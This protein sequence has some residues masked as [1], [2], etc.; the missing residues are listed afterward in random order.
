MAMDLTGILQGELDKSQKV[1]ANVSKDQL[2]ATTGCP[3]FDVRG[4]INHM[5]EANVMFGTVASGGDYTPNNDK[6]NL[7]DDHVA[8][9][10][11]AVRSAIDGFSSEGAMERPCSFPFGEMPGSQ[12]VGVA[13]LETVTHRWD[14][15]KAT[16]QD[17]DIDDGTAEFLLAGAQQ[18]GL[19]Q[20][21]GD[22][23]A[24]F[25]H[26]QPCSDDAPAVNKLMAYLGRKI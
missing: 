24:A 21:R 19:D 17:P 6:D 22:E 23:G 16:G 20:F 12:A 11:A 14:V 5:A 4:L 3:G 26:A 9:H 15:A 7:G 18:A 25:G 8:A 13:I 10:A 1:V 2:G